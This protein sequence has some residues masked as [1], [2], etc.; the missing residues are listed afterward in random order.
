MR[1]ALQE[2]SSVRP[3]RTGKLEAVHIGR[4]AFQ[5]ERTRCALTDGSSTLGLVWFL[6]RR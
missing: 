2:S 3:W 6:L 4:V 1:L 5:L